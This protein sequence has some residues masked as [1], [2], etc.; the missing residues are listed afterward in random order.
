M[1]VPEVVKKIR[2]LREVGWG[3][4][5]IAQQLG[6][7]RGT[8]RRYVRAT[9]E[10][11]VVQRRPG[12][13]TPGSEAQQLAVK[14]LDGAAA[15]NGVVVRRLLRERGIEAPLRTVQ[16]VL[17]PHRRARGRRGRDGAVRDGASAPDADRLW[18]EAG[19]GGRS[20]AARVPVRSG[21][22]VLATAVFATVVEPA[23]GR[24][25]PGTGGGVQALRWGSANVASGQRGTA[26][27]GPGPRD[28][29]GP[30][31]SRVRSVLSRLGSKARVCQ[32]YRARTKG[33]RVEGGLRQTE[34][35]D[36]PD[37]RQ[38]RSS[39]ASP[40]AV[41]GRGGRAHSRD[42]SRAS[43]GAFRAGRAQAP[44]RCRP[45]LWLHA[46]DAW[47]GRWRRTASWTWTP[48]ATASRTPRSDR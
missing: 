17:T 44:G 15:G 11:A 42:H 22:G 12:A 45:T 3:A 21:A 39:A 6:V 48:S 33:N 30:A 37:L 40:G 28:K 36:R 23:P 16:R 14:L 43:H 46:R 2:Q 20:G 27:E 41:D 34:R 4:K 38:L 24:L 29:H 26:G 8:V 32:P 25:G 5:R 47:S 31:A 9:G 7:A 1:L 10:G 35:P 13:W 18:R 19:R